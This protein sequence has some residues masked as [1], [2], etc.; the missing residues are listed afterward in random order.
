MN[1]AMWV[2]AGGILG[3]IGFAMLDANRERG[4][5][6]SVVIGVLG[7]FFGGNVLAPML[8]AVTDTPNDFS[9]FS[10]VIAMTSA[11]ACLAI[12]NLVS[13]RYSA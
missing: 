3:W 12:G 8:G 7:G 2:V 5:I 6:V 9:L 11:A 10:L 4:M 1:I 13:N